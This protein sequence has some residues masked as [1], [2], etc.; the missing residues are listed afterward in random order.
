MGRIGGSQRGGFQKGGFGGCSWP[1]K[2]RN[3]GTK[4]GT[5]VQKPVFLDPKNWN[6]GIKKER[7][8]KKQE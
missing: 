1:Q 3:E 8:Y 4:T 7:R 2:H 5:R 6:E